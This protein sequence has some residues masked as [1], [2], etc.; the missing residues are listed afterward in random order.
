MKKFYCDADRL[1]HLGG[2][3]DNWHG[4]WLSQWSTNELI[5]LHT[6]HMSEQSGM[7]DEA[8]DR[9]PRW[10]L[11]AVLSLEPGAKLDKETF[12]RAKALEL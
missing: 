2:W 12:E 6:F 8:I 11:D 4:N 3:L 7:I 1:R 9:W 10:L 5:K